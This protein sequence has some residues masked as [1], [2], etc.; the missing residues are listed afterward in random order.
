MKYSIEI[1]NLTQ[2]DWESLAQSFA[3][4][5]IYQTWPYQ[6][7]RCEMDDQQLNRVIVKNDNDQVVLMCQIRI[8]RR[9]L[10]PIAIGY[11]QWGP[12][13]CPKNGSTIDFLEP[14]ELLRDTYL[15]G[16]V[17]MLRF[18]PNVEDNEKGKSVTD[19]LLNADF[20]KVDNISPYYTMMF[21]LDIPQDEML[22]RIKPRWRRDLRK[23]E[24]KDIKIV[25]LNGMK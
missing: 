18:V 5:N 19:L 14:L 23:A 16:K 7:I 2:Y 10:L 6:Q 15:N 24:K 8:K 17:N 13:I 9:P 22:A 4:Y 25:I 21:P 1:D 3:D 12:L 11:V 20:K